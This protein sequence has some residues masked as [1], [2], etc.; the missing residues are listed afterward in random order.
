MRSAKIW[1]PQ[2]SS[3]WRNKEKWDGKACHVQGTWEGPTGIWWSKLN[4]TDCLQDLYIYRRT[5]LNWILQKLVDRK[6]TGPIRLWIVTG[7]MFLWT[8]CWNELHKMRSIWLTEK[9][10]SFT[11]GTLICVVRIAT[12]HTCSSITNI[13]IGKGKAV[14]L[15][16][17]TGPEGSR[18]LRLPGFKTI[19]TW[20]WWGCQLIQGCNWPAYGS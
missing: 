4:E 19:S 11:Q 13:Y 9:P 3:V 8:W 1:F 20:R 12:P 15:Q 16:A 7:G 5:I 10:L 18:R 17:W 2:I 6:W 14:P